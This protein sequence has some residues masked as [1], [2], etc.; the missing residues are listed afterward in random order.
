MM[1]RRVREKKAIRLVVC[2]PLFIGCLH[3]IECKYDRVD[4]VSGFSNRANFRDR[5]AIEVH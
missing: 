2:Q 3:Q 4:M 1:A 5:S